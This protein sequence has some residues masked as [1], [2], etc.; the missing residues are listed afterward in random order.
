[1]QPTSQIAWTTTSGAS[2]V[3]SFGGSSPTLLQQISFSNGTGQLSL[4]VQNT[5]GYTTTTYG[6]TLAFAAYGSTAGS[7]RVDV[8]GN[9]SGNFSQTVYYSTTQTYYYVPFTA[10]TFDT[11]FTIYLGGNSP[12]A[13]G[14]QVF[15]ETL[16]VTDFSMYAGAISNNLEGTLTLLNG[17]LNA[18]S[19]YASNTISSPNIDATSAL[20][21]S[22]GAIS[23]FQG[24][25]Y[26]TAG[27][28][29]AT[30]YFQ[31]MNAQVLA[32][33]GAG[34]F[35]SI[36]TTTATAST[37]TVS[38]TATF[39][40]I[41]ATS[42]NAGSVNT[43]AL[44]SGSVA[45]SAGFIATNGA[46]FQVFSGTS[47][48]F[49]VNGQGNTSVNTLTVSGTA[50]LQTLTCTAEMDTGALTVSG[51]GSF[52]TVISTNQITSLGG[53]FAKGTTAGFGLY[54]GSSF[55]FLV[56]GSGNTTTQNLTAQGTAS[57]Q[58]LTCTGETD[59]G[60]LTCTTLT[61]TGESD[62]GV[63]TCTGVLNA[64]GGIKI[65]SYS[66]PLFNNGSFTNTT[67]SV[68]I[69]IYFTS[70]SYNFVEVKASFFT[71]SGIT[72]TMTGNTNSTGSG[73]S[74]TPQENTEFS[75]TNVTPTSTSTTTNGSIEINAEGNQSHFKLTM[76]KCGT[77]QSRNFY[78]FDTI[79]TLKNVGTQHTTGMGHLDS[80]YLASIVLTA[81][82]GSIGG[83]WNTVHYY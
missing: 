15:P 23:T 77:Y 67:A 76:G 52:G 68:A 65:N 62:S 7:L 73:T 28:T 60:T 50:N 42:V 34:T 58:A 20:V 47:S 57:L 30:G 16:F 26:S 3:N 45:S 40:P 41:A 69:P 51:T 32:V 17:N 18:P 74:L 31:S 8:T 13:A 9:S 61:C 21:T 46:G 33:S 24:P 72:I 2:Y 48:P 4:V 37:L 75:T 38:N 36:S 80:T 70:S 78:N 83:F 14:A 29:G 12:G 27:F 1:M 11:Q 49:F 35:S 71:A 64:N 19:V 81:S 10:G 53:F 66:L 25:V 43:N 54:S 56:D 22:A 79:Y 55:P 63:L 59:T 82:S 39:G 5:S 44:T 6:A